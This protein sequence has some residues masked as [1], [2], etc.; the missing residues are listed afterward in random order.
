M[1]PLATLREALARVAGFGRGVASRN[2]AA[3]AMLREEMEAH[4][5]MH[6]AENIRRGMTPD[7]A[8]RDA[9]QALGNMTAGVES[10]RGQLLASFAALAGTLAIL[11]LYSV[12][13]YL[14][15]EQTREIGIRIALGADGRRVLGFVLGQGAVLTALG[16][17]IGLAAAWAGARTMESLVYEVSVHDGW[18]FAATAAVLTAVALL[19]SYLPAR[20]ASRTDPV[21]ALRADG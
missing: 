2:G 11:G 8:R 1:S 18:T 4:F 14:V 6:V 19:A 12:M 13:S 21:G 9:R 15:S 16:V 3:D 17:G 20:R 5:E 10:V 7:A